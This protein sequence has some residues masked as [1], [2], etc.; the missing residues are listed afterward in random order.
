MKPS[1]E[2]AK[3]G[4]YQPLSR[5]LFT[6]PRIDALAEEHIAEFCRYFVEQSANRELVANE[7]GYVPNTE[8][9]M[10]TQ[11]EELNSAIEEAQ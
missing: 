10:Q 6:Y 8:E 4:E 11:L 5:P 2:T 9:T 3:S 7:I 1:L